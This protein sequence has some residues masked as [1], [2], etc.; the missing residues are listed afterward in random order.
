MLK[1]IQGE[2]LLRAEEKTMEVVLLH[3][4]ADR[5]DSLDTGIS[6]ID[7]VFRGQD[8][9]IEQEHEVPVRPV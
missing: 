1:P 3:S 2:A 7:S 8:V 4:L 9:V 6:A 5:A